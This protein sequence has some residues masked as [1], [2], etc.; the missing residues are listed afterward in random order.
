M[1]LIESGQ[2]EDQCQKKVVVRARASA[3]AAALVAAAGVPLAVR[4]LTMTEATS[5]IMKA[6]GGLVGL[7]LKVFL[8]GAAGFGILVLG[9]FALS[10]ISSR[11]KI[12]SKVSQ[13][14]A[15]AV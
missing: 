12:T 11:V 6:G 5:W 13:P 8:F 15:E 2:I 4:G 7:G 9:R 10:T 14:V 1:Y 3:L